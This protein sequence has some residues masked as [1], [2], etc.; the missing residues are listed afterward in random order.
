MN[1]LV[2]GEAFKDRYHT[3]TS[4]RLSPE[5]PVPVV[6]IT[7]TFDLQGGAANVYEN[8][9]ALGAVGTLVSQPTTWPVK[10]RLLMGDT[11]LARWDEQDSAE[12][13]CARTFVKLGRALTLADGI[14]LSDYGKGMFTARSIMDLAGYLP[15][16]PLF[17][18]TKQNPNLFY[19]LSRNAFYF[20]NLKEYLTYQDGYD[21]LGSVVRTEGAHGMSYLAGGEVAFSI[22]AFATSVRSVI[23]AGDSVVA[24]F[25]YKYLQSTQD[26]A[27][28]SMQEILT[29]V[30]EY[31]AKVVGQPYT[32]G[33]SMNL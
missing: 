12:P 24:A 16:V 25:A 22:P 23:G 6:T 26:Q 30:S 1:I 27:T 28:S 29:W 21:L 2:I 4:T 31:A 8:L 9:K 11:Q 3:G 20:P 7:R 18:D 17:I 33:S 10:N 19:G 14:I 5:A 32:S 13:L 15:P